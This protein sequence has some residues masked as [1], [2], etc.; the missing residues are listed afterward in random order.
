MQGIA[1]LLNAFGKCIKALFSLT[2]PSVQPSMPRKFGSSFW[3]E[4]VYITDSQLTKSGSDTSKCEMRK[5]STRR[6]VDFHE[7]LC[8][9][10]ICSCGS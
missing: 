4:E 8:E 2:H 5:V 3:P 7:I 6:C 9:R 1:L 10:L